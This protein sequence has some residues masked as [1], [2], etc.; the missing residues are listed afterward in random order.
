MKTLQ[1]KSNAAFTL[2]EIMLVVM[3]IAILAGSAIY[4]MRG[5]VDQAAIVRA[6]GDIQQILTQLQMYAVRNGTAPTTA[7]GLEALVTRP[8]GEPQPRK[9]SQ[10]MKDLPLDPWGQ[11]YQ[12]RNPGTISRDG[13]DVFSAGPD[14]QPGN[15]DDIGNW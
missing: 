15:A 4:L 1:R 3:I 6:E 10:L 14:R 7:Q 5:Q 12:L 13:Y 9:W 8:T 2:L 11:P